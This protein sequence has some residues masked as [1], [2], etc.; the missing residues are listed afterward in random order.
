MKL[1]KVVA[2]I[3]VYN[4]EKTIGFVVS[5]TKKYVDE[6]IVVDDGSFDKSSEVAEK[7]VAKVIRLPVNRGVSHA[8]KVGLEEALKLEPDVIVQLDGDGQHNPEDIPKLLEPIKK[9]ETDIVVG[10]RFLERMGVDMPKIKR[11][12]NKIFSIILSRMCHTKITDSQSGF[13][14]Y[15]RNVAQS[16]DLISSFS[17]TQEFLVHAYH[18]DFK[19]LEVPISVNKRSQGESKVAG[20][21][22]YY[23][24]LQLTTLLRVYRDYKPVKTFGLV[25]VLFITLGILTALFGFTYHKHQFSIGLIGLLL[26]LTGTQIFFFGLSSEKKR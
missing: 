21:V 20:N 17:Y 8:V 19:I 24:L 5:E 10:S 15:T 25:A 22:L 6:V 1:L 23:A 16:I 9:G 13:R 14:A 4:E 2:V 18:N 7:S 3:P 12:G 11:L 26:I